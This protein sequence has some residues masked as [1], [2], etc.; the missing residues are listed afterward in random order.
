MTQEPETKA[1]RRQKKK[2]KRMRQ[3]GR[4]LKRVPG[5]WAERAQ[6]SSEGPSQKDREE[7]S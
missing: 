3:S 4:G 2:R 5:L 7:A 6:K 1:E